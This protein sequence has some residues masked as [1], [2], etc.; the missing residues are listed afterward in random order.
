MPKD[1]AVPSSM[2]EGGMDSFGRKVEKL[3]S[4]GVPDWLGKHPRRAVVN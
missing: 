4:E 1:N 3:R 2:K